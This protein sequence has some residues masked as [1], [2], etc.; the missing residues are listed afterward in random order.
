[1]KIF[2]RITWTREAAEMVAATIAAAAAAG[3]YE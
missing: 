3:V 1:M 2:L